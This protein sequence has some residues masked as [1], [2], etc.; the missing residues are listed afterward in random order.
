MRVAMER[1]DITPLGTFYME[2]YLTELRRQP[3]LGVH[4]TPYAFLLLIEVG[5]ERVLFVSLDV[6]I[7]TREL[8]QPMRALLEEATGIPAERIVINAIHSHACATGFV[9]GLIGKKS[10]GY[11]N[12]VTGLVVEAATRLEGKLEK[13]AP[14][15]LRT[16][17]RGWYSNRNDREREFDD[18]AYLLRFA[19]TVG[20]VVAAML[21]FN[22]HATVVGPENRYLTPDV[23]GSVR[24]HLASWIG[25]MPYTFTGASGD[26]G[27]RQYRQGNDFQELER[28]GVGIASE[29]MKAPFEPVEFSQAVVRTFRYDVAYDNAAYHEGYQ[30]KLDHVRELLAGPLSYDERKLYDTAQTMLEDQLAVR[31]VSFALE[32]VTI[33]FGPLVFVTFPG[34]L[35][36]ELGL[37]IKRMFAGKT[38][39]VMGYA[40][41]YQGYFVKQGDFGYN[42]EALITKLPEGGIERI[43]DAFEES[44]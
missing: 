34:E 2:G 17:V 25:V 30:R 7:I 28:V 19:N 12:K 3:A 42:Y 23:I 32:M 9:E 44:R 38:C 26:V 33:D 11:E 5:A 1:V 6:C 4:D 39:L 18:E 16:K 36:S 37:R 29:I 43:L 15:L 21:N 41:D 31:D 20:Q 22:C 14:E 40:N 8:T 13:V 35:A 27:N 10:L 24:A